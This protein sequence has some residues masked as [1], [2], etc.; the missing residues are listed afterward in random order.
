M[1]REQGIQKGI[2]TFEN[3]SFSGDARDIN[4]LSFL[5]TKHRR[6]ENWVRY[7][8]YHFVMYSLLW[9][10]KICIRV[11]HIIANEIYFRVRIPQLGTYVR[12]ADECLGTD[13]S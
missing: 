12:N 4:Q 13:S 3:C 10:Q 9:S 11:F 8:Q 2:N 6:E 1:T 5:S 7:S